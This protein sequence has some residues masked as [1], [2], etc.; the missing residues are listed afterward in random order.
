MFWW[1]QKCMTYLLES[2]G[3][4]LFRLSIVKIPG[5]EVV[6]KVR[7]RIL[8]FTTLFEICLLVPSVICM[9]GLILWHAWEEMGLYSMLQIYLKVLFPQLYHLTLDLLDF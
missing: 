1:N 8:Y 7:Q 3:L 4:D 2:Q 9:R 6:P 5:T